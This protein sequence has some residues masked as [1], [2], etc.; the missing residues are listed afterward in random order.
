MPAIGFHRINPTTGRTEVW[1]GDNYG[2]QSP[3]SYRLIDNIPGNADPE[4]EV[5][6]AAVNNRTPR[7]QLL[8]LLNVPNTLEAWERELTNS[9]KRTGYQ[10]PGIDPSK[11]FSNVNPAAAFGGPLLPA[12]TTYTNP[13]TKESKEYA[14]ATD[15]LTSQLAY[16]ATFGLV[17]NLGLLGINLVQRLEDGNLYNN[18][19]DPES[20]PL[21][22]IIVNTD[23]A[24]REAAPGLE[25]PEDR[26][27][28]AAAFENLGAEIPSTIVGTSLAT[29][30]VRA[31]SFT[32]GAFNKLSPGLQRTLRWISGLGIES[33]VSTIG[34]SD[35]ALE[36]NFLFPLTADDDMFSAT[37][38]AL[39]PNALVE[40]LLNGGIGATGVAVGRGGQFTYNNAYRNVSQW[41][42]QYT[43]I[44][45]AVDARLRLEDW[46][47]ME[48]VGDGRYGFTEEPAAPKQ[49]AETATDTAQGATAAPEPEVKAQPEP[50]A[51]PVAK[52]KTM[53]EADEQLL[54]PVDEVDYAKPE[55]DT[56][57]QALDELDDTQLQAI[58]EGSV[59]DQVEAGLEQAANTA[60]AEGMFVGDMLIANEALATPTVPYID[61]WEQ[62]PLNRLLGM[63][64][65]GNNAALARSIEQVTGKDG[66]YTRQ[67]VLAGLQNLQQQGYTMVPNR[68]QEGT[69]LMRTADLKTDAKRFQYKQGTD[70]A[71]VQA[72]NSLDGVS[73]WDPESEG[74][75]SVWTDNDGTTY[76]VNGHNR[77]AKA[78]ELGIPTLRVRELLASNFL[79]A[80]QLGAMENIKS[81]QGTAVD[82]AIF[83][84]DS[85]IDSVEKAEAAGFPMEGDKN[86]APQG[87]ALA[88][89]PESLFRELIDE[90]LPL[91]RAVELGKSN[92]SPEAMVRVARKG[93]QS[94]MSERGFRELVQLAESAPEISE[95]AATGQ[96]AL[97]G[98][99]SMLD[100]LAIKA[101]LAGKVRADINSS[102]NLF[103]K[104][105]KKRAQ[106][107]LDE[108]GTVV[109]AAAAQNR[110]QMLQSLLGDFDA[111]KGMT[112]NKFNDLLNEGVEDIAGGAKVNVI[113][114]RIVQQISNAAEEAPPVEAPA[115]KAAEGGLTDQ[116]KRALL[117]MTPAER[118]DVRAK[119][120][121]DRLSEKVR[122]N[123]EARLAE[124]DAQNA[125]QLEWMND[126]TDIEQGRMSLED[127]EAKWGV[128]ARDAEEPPI[129]MVKKGDYNK[130][131]N[132]IKKDDYAKA[133][134][135]FLDN[136][137][138][139]PLTAAARNELKKNITRQ[140]VNN[141]EVR[142]SETPIPELPEGPRDMSDPVKLVEDEVRLAGDYARAEEVTDF[143]ATR[144]RQEAIGY[145]DMPVAEKKANGMLDGWET[146]PPVTKQGFDPLAEVISNPNERFTL[147]ADVVKSK[148]RFGMA[149]LVFQDD[150]D[151]A[152]YIIRNSGKKSKGEDR[153]V[154]A[155]TEQGYDIGAVRRLGDDVKK[156]IQ[157]VIE[158]ATGSRRAPQES[159]E[160]QVPR[161]EIDLETVRPTAEGNARAALS[162]SLKKAGRP[163]TA[164]TSQ[165]TV[166]SA[167]Q[168]L[169][170]WA[171]AGTPNPPFREW[172]DALPV[173]RKKGAILNLEKVE[174][175]NYDEALT[176]RNM[177]IYKDDFQ[178]AKQAVMEF[179][180]LD[181]GGSGNV[182]SAA[183]APNR[184]SFATGEAQR[185]FEAQVAL[186][187]DL[188]EI[189]RRVAGDNPKIDI[190]GDKQ[191][192][193]TT[194]S[195][196]AGG[197]P[198]TEVGGWYDV[199]KDIVVVAD[200]FNQPE[201]RLRNVAYHEAFHRL[202]FKNMSQKDINILNSA[203]GRAAISWLDDMV[204][205]KYL[206]SQTRAYEYFSLMRDIGKKPVDK[207]FKDTLEVWQSE[208]PLPNGL[209]WAEVFRGAAARVLATAWEGLRENLERT[210]N[211]AQGN[212]FRS[213]YDLFEDTYSGRFVQKRQRIEAETE[214]FNEKMRQG[215]YEPSKDRAN[216]EQPS[217]FLGYM[218]RQEALQDW[219]ADAS[220]AL[221]KH[222]WYFQEEID[223]LKKQA[224]EGGC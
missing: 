143:A 41:N 48:D 97:P 221:E 2:Y 45:R 26:P 193:D 33:G 182:Y 196:W 42:R 21:G 119:A 192:M 66:N 121:K 124:Y 201:I 38:K 194:D 140:A 204:P 29:S 170:D 91:S 220:M 186:Q 63:A 200:A 203:M 19:A 79:Q 202:Q 185:S 25:L 76:V 126:E 206:E 105:S 166:D 142:P 188:T 67:D 72:G 128:G 115:P 23:R 137:P 47:I 168:S 217:K 171:N 180:G 139:E 106:Q 85:G 208:F 53:A 86:L 103:G 80:R 176:Q 32:A 68:A 46:G 37:M 138:E 161:S 60:P 183:P 141:G 15:P 178:K 90:T 74:E 13:K 167:A 77:Y 133:V 10:K 44:S 31:T 28:D 17:K 198:N 34:T 107:Q 179:Y 104:V 92:L 155:L 16:G 96:T 99:E 160:I 212:G 197:G 132:A 181:G 136:Q 110:K 24:I 56:V 18:P 88:R 189:I 83:L 224:K 50:A 165:R 122:G 127:Y 7:E 191:F 5:V 207:A 75:I 135:E 215:N 118:A 177:G 22:K 98:M 65:G 152:A 71:G 113:A 173:V 6:N 93:E 120:E 169:K 195:S 158:E 70:A 114:K 123:R 81:G 150:L 213:V 62:L 54:G 214:F 209:K 134:L 61:Q 111:G 187:E 43:D 89:L 219:A 73:R 35:Q 172:G 210:I 151:R 64:D 8:G 9:E 205:K 20:N 58:G 164:K 108:A 30:A 154:A 162:D 223:A 95:A 125:R 147:P 163:I 11:A 211:L 129:Y 4:K 130:V 218:E 101:E 40:I 117:E 57:V 156:S 94:N 102:K 27:R 153:I 55:A 116:Q 174:G 49:P 12:T 87:L 78:K 149:R 69:V 159:V 157:D 36:G 216:W 184:F 3:E 175:L 131:A 84:R 199:A 190:R 148:P 82:A 14:G 146:P 59:V 222:H 112:G 145:D 1:A 52:P 144:A 109:D 39:L 51:E 100:T